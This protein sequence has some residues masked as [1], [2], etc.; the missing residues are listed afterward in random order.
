M[1][2]KHCLSNP[3]ED[4]AI[5]YESGRRSKILERVIMPS[6]GLVIAP[7]PVRKFTQEELDEYNRKRKSSKANS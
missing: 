3:K 6:D 1:R 2:F 4:E 7:S 5:E